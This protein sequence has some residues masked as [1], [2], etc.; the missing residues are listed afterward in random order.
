MTMIQL[1]HSYFVAGRRDEALKLRE[2]VLALRGKRFSPEHPAILQAKNDLAIS[3]D[4]AG[5]KE[6]ALKLREEV[7]S[8]RL[9]HFGPDQTST[10]IAMGHLANSYLSAGRRDEALKLREEVLAICRRVKGAQHSRTL[11]AMQDLVATYDAVGRK[12]ETLKL[13]AELLALQRRTLGPEH[14]STMAVMDGLRSFHLKWQDY[15]GAEPLATELLDHAR[16][17]GDND[18]AKLESRL[19]EMAHVRYRLQQFAEAESLL[20]ERIASRRRRSGAEQSE[21]VLGTSASLGR[22]LSDWAWVERATNAVAAL[23]HAREGEALLRKV[24]AARSRQENSPARTGDAQ[25]RLGHALCVLAVTDSALAPA[26]R[27]VM[28]LEAEKLLRD[29]HTALESDRRSD[30]NHRRD[31]M[32]RFVRLYTAWTNPEL[33]A[34]WQEKILAF[35]R[36]EAARRTHAEP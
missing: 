34:Q 16:K 24:L 15:A 33:L 36:D 35:D 13:A 4:L 20:R 7:C 29:G 25:S 32:E 30:P 14:P 1:A 27:E 8:T 23:A 28:L 31:S 6:E 10:L 5:R 3:Y 12:D 17:E 19:G 11:Q 26:A 18:P 9:K 21:T 2:E 22:L